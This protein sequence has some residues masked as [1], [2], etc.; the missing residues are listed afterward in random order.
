MSDANGD[1]NHIPEAVKAIH[2]AAKKAVK[3]A[4]LDVEGHAKVNAPV[5]T[6]YL[7]NSI[8]S[9]TA[10]SSDYHGGDKSLPE[11]G[12]PESDTEAIVAVGA[13]YGIFQEYGTRHMPAQPYLT[14][15]AD[16][17]RGSISQVFAALIAAEI[18]ATVK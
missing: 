6:G 10:D 17:V 16:L 4:A 15:A 7:R 18:K 14:P 2:E 5:D 3:K 12:K 8:Y 13:S 11:V 9:V 1:Y